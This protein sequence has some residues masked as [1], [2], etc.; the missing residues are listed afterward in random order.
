MW[1]GSIVPSET[2]NKTLMHVCAY[3]KGERSQ[4]SS[5]YSVAPKRIK[6][7]SLNSSSGN[8]P[9]MLW[10]D[11]LSQ[12]RFYYFSSFKTIYMGIQCRLSLNS[13]LPATWFQC[14]SLPLSSFNKNAMLHSH[15][16]LHS[17][18]QTC[19]CAC[20]CAHTA[21]TFCPAYSTPGEN[22][23]RMRSRIHSVHLFFTTDKTISHTFEHFLHVANFY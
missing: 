23:T 1:E 18:E 21:V 12:K 13:S 9:L 22:P 8:L 2:L 4:F 19:L 14:T 16:C 5:Y 10:L 11:Q 17:T 3:F 15:C 6:V 7:A 20:A